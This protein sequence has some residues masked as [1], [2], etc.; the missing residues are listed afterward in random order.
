MI[1]ENRERDSAWGSLWLLL[2]PQSKDMLVR[3]TD[4]SKLAVGVNVSVDG[5][6]SLCVGTIDYTVQHVPRLRP[7]INDDKMD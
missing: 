6:F 2:L 1:G 4:N 3:L 5:C 7:K